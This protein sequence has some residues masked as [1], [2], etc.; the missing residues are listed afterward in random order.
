VFRS[1]LNKISRVGPERTSGP[2]PSGNR[3][4]SFH[5]FWDV[6]PEP[7]A[8]VSATV[9][10]IEPPAVARLYF[11]ALQ[12]SFDKDGRPRGAAHFGLQHHPSYPG[13]GAV[14]W[15]GYHHRGGELDG[16]LSHLPSALGNRNTRN[17]GWRPHQPYRYRIWRSPE[18]GWR[19]SV[20]DLASGDETAVRDLWIDGQ[21]MMSPM[22]WTEAFAD[23]DD[24]PAAVRWSDL[25]VVTLSGHRHRVDAVRLNYQS[26]GDGGC[27]NTDSSLDRSGFVQ[28]TATERIAATGSRLRLGPIR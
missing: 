20:T 17:Y 24:P 27:T 4:S 14:N 16:S 13:S 2:P 12:T 10:V 3:A 9:E 1:I 7:L 23:C 19:A 21:S 5:L 11:W 26:H 28:R 8:E 18:R 22:V 6:P 25:E 15:G